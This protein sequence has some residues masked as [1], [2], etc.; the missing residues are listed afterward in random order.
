MTNCK[1]IAEAGINHNG[2]FNTALKLVDEAKKIGADFIKFQ[3]YKTE[4]L[5][6]KKAKLADYQSV[7]TKKTNQYDLLKLNELTFEQQLN[8]V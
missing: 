8:L 2:R 5:T 7:N 1:I 4:N 3:I 6:I